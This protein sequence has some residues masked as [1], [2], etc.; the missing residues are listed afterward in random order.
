[1]TTMTSMTMKTRVGGWMG[2]VVV[3]VWGVGSIPLSP[4]ASPPT[5]SACWP[6]LCARLPRAPRDEPRVSGGYVRDK[7]GWEHTLHHT[8]THIIIIII[9][10][11]MILEGPR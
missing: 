1:M 9:I 5:S 4:Q 10:I 2:W 11:I 3:G 8:R 6:T 7:G